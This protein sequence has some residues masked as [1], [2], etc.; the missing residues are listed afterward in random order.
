MY[1]MGR[2][3]G[4]NDLSWRDVWFHRTPAPC[5]GS[6]IVAA[7]RRPAGLVTGGSRGIGAATVTALARHCYD[8][9]FTYRNKRAR[10]SQVANQVEQLGARALAAECDITR[11][12]DVH[13]LF[14]EVFDWAGHLDVLVLNASGGLERDLL[15]ADPDY[16]MRINRDAQL[17]VVDSALPFM[18]SGGT[19]VFVTSHW[20]HR[21]GQMEQL[22]VYEPI[23]AS[24]HAGEVALLARLDDF[25]ARGIR[26]LVVSGDLI[27]GT[28]TPKLLERAAP[29]LTAQR[30]DSMGE[31]TTADEMGQAIA[32]AATNPSLPTGSTIVVGES[33]YPTA[34]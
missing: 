10:A 22:P 13:R 2:M 20:A 5:D 9:A 11:V 8:L 12:D 14:A 29:G 18:S 17:L 6:D 34:K 21:Y 23:A 15:A 27:A 3:I 28:I 30:R 7:N 31:L 19:I 32:D 16:P 26:L 33:F 24:K 25:T 1:D 4:L